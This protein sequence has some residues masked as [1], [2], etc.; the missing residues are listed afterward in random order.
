MLN[1]L[2]PLLETALDAVVVIDRD[3][4]I[5][6]WNAS[7]A[8]TFGWSEDEVIG[9]QMA[10][11]IVPPS[12]REAHCRGLARF[13]ATGEARVLNT[14]F[15]IEA[16]DRSGRQFPVE[17]AI[18]TATAEGEPVFVGFI[19]DI[20]E[21][22]QAEAR[23]ASQAREAQLLFDVTRLAADTDSFEEA[24]RACL[25]AICSLTGWQAGHALLRRRGSET[26]LIS[27]GVWYEHAPGVA[28]GLKAATEGLVFTPGRG[29]PGAV[30]ESG[31][32][33]WIS[34]SARHPNFP[35][36]GHGFGSAFAFPVMSQGR[37]AAVL[38]F[39]GAE[40]AEPDAELM[41]TVRTLGEQ[42]GRVLERK[43]T[44]ERQRLLI[45]ELNHR[46]KNT[47]AVVQ[48]V[49]NQSFRGNAADPAAKADFERRL[50]A[51]AAAHDVLSAE[52]WRSASMTEVVRKSVSGC[53]AFEERVRLDGPELQVS[54]R[55][56]VSLAMALHELCTNAVKY[57]AL[58]NDQGAIGISWGTDGEADEPRFWLEWREQ[59]GP[60]VTP[61]SRR[62]FGT[63]M[64]ERVLAAELSGTAEMR[65]EP[66]GLTC[67]IDAPFPSA[68]GS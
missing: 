58:S 13:N 26:G 2:R 51:L 12:Y 61:P 21:R 15:E 50:Q 56:A 33:V 32:P 3:G 39:F 27:A 62:G 41:L 52:S 37:I 54:P 42:V 24:L 19:R 31:E 6:G 8:A 30:L 14:R 44:E 16:L 25:E 66:D 60:P 1:A 35:R 43:R 46:V 55:A 5:L 9:R 59:D 49:A 7:A 53:G 48:S 64:I 34:D 11:T 20:S 65:F 22:R 28:D 10:E 18:A 68:D 4:I 45:N 47:L 67:R 40:N 38:E 17:L 57:G 63:R 29:L 23:L 36:K